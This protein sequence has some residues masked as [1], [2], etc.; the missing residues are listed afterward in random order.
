[1]A[2]QAQDRKALDEFL[3][4]ERLG[5]DGGPELEI[6]NREFGGRR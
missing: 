1:L 2:V 5:L 6:H 4:N 3:G